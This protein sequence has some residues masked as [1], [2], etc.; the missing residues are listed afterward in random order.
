MSEKASRN[1][2]A[3]ESADLTKDLPGIPSGEELALGPVE[4]EE[5]DPLPKWWDEPLASEKT[6][7][8]NRRIE[9]GI[10]FEA[11]RRKKPLPRLD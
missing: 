7:S 2:G 3:D 8:G 1:E 9:D 10:E 11:P 5:I 4:G 6:K